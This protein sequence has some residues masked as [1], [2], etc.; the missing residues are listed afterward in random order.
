M[1]LENSLEILKEIF[2]DKPEALTVFDLERISSERLKNILGGEEQLF[3][4]RIN[5]WV[6]GKTHAGKTSLGNSL[7]DSKIMKSTGIIDCTDFIGFF[8]L[9]AN[10]RFFDVPGYASR[11]S[12]ENINRVALSMPQIEDEDAEPPAFEMK[13]GETFPLKDFTDCKTPEDEPDTKNIAVEE[14][15]SPAF[16]ADVEPDVIIYMNAPHALFLRADRQ[17]LRQLLQAWQKRKT[18]CIIIPVLNIFEGGNRPTSQNIEDSK[19]AIK[20]VY[21]KVYGDKEY[22]SV[23]EIN[24]LKG[25]GIDTLT[26]AICQILP[27]EKIGN[28]QKVLKDELKKYAEKEQLIRYYSTISLIAGRLAFYTSDDKILG[29]RNKIFFVAAEAIIYYVAMIFKGKEILQDIQGQMDAIE[30]KVYELEDERKEDIKH[31][32]DA[33]FETEV[34]VDVPIWKKVRTKPKEIPREVTKTVYE[35]QHYKFEVLDPRK[36]EGWPG[37]IKDFFAPRTKTMHIVTHNEKVVTETVIDKKPGKKKKVLVGM[38]QEY[39]PVKLTKQVEKIVGQKSI[40]G[41]YPLIELL[42]TLGVSIKHF[43]NQEE[44][45]LLQS[46]VYAN[47]VVEDKLLGIRSKI[48]N[49]VK[50]REKE[51]E[52]V[53]LLEKILLELPTNS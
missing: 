41:G 49:L 12:Y 9:G 22:P 3:A 53:Q 28:M 31:L 7:L 32:E 51:A 34:A 25:L 5:F 48:E 35:P 52:L 27:Q 29:G 50:T 14:W 10:L 42:V 44:P 17:Y 2:K 21:R 26:D 36:G 33:E 24:S 8:R 37:K 18:N 47:E 39:K 19:Q 23:I 11:G 46:M 6:T 43:C 38:K 4:T 16:Q 40:E 15:Q 1:S 20:D 45:K 30:S 13:A